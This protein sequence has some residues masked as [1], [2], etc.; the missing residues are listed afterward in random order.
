VTWER[1][2]LGLETA[3][4]VNRALRWFRRGRK[5]AEIS[6][7]EAPALHREAERDT[8]GNF[9]RQ[10]HLH[11]WIGRSVQGSRR[12]V[13]RFLTSIRCRGGVLYEC[14]SQ[15]DTGKYLILV[16]FWFRQGPRRCRYECQVHHAS[17]QHSLS[18]RRIIIKPQLT[19]RFYCG[20]RAASGV[21]LTFALHRTTSSNANVKSKTPLEV[22]IC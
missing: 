12:L 21:D 14:R 6:A 3:P 2:P 22:Y 9:G 8:T 17:Q 4:P 11:T 19:L 1:T 13:S 15:R 16:E 7:L 10:H 18:F 20:K 5:D